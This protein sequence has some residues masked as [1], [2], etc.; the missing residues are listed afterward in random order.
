MSSS[1]RLV[2][3]QIASDSKGRSG[4]YSR[5]IRAGSAVPLYLA[6]VMPGGTLRFRMLVDRSVNTDALVRTTAGYTL[7]IV[8]T[9]KEQPAEINIDLLRHEYQEIFIQMLDAIVPSIAEAADGQAAVDELKA[10]LDLWA[11]FMRAF[12]PDGLSHER[13]RGLF[14]ELVVLKRLLKSTASQSR[15]IDSWQGPSGASQDFR[16]LDSAVE[17]KTVLGDGRVVAVSSAYQLD[18]LGLSRMFL[19]CIALE[20]SGSDA[21][22]LPQCVDSVKACLPTDLQATFSAKL[23]LAGYM[24]SQRDLYAYPTFRVKSVEAYN[25]MGPFPAI[26]A[27]ILPPPIRQ[28]SYEVDLSQCGD[29]AVDEA[30]WINSLEVALR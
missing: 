29:Y 10:Q 11:R 9:D 20:E 12:M 5:R 15:V 26:R 1:I 6:V 7:K 16:A 18:T 27:S 21:V 19:L 25:A 13:Q 28:V 17:V 30:A 22:S 8:A 4:I 3:D 14:G 24:E 2:F 23:L